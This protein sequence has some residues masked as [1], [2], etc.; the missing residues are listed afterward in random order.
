MTP[1][2]GKTV[3]AALAFLLFAVGHVAGVEFKTRTL[4]EKLA[5]PGLGFLASFDQRHINADLASGRKKAC[6]HA[7]I[8]LELRGAIGF[9]GNFA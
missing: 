3:S 4:A 9:D 8:S 7:D 6:S 5:E 1:R 2:T